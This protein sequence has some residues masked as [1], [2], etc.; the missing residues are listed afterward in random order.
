MGA[1]RSIIKVAILGEEKGLKEAVHLATADLDKLQKKATSASEKAKASA[2]KAV[3]FMAGG[4]IAIAGIA[5]KNGD[6]LNES[7]DQLANSLQN[8]GQS[9]AGLDKKMSPLQKTMEKYGYT[10]V[11]VN[12]SIRAQVESGVKLA[13]AIKRETLIAD[14]AKKKHLDLATATMLVTKAGQGLTKP[15]KA[16][17][18]D[19]PLAAGGALKLATAQ[20]A[21][22]KAHNKVKDAA[23]RVRDAE[24]KA[25][26][27]IADARAKHLTGAAAAKVYA[28]AHDL[29]WKASD[30]LN[31]AQ[32]V[33]RAAQK[34]V[35]DTRATGT[36]ILDLLT[37]RMKGGAEESTKSLA[38]KTAA[39][40]AK[41]TDMTAH[42]GQKLIPILLTLGTDIGAIVEWFGKNKV[43]LDVL[44][45]AVGLFVAS[46][47]TMFIIEKV[48][49]MTEAWTAAQAAFNLVMDANPIVL[50]VGAIALLA[51]GL[52][53]AYQKVGWFH[54]AVDKAWQILQ[55]GYHWIQDNWPLLLAILTGPFGLAVLAIVKNRDKIISFIKEIPGKIA[56]FAGTLWSG[57]TGAWDAAVHWVGKRG[58]A[59]VTWVKNLPGVLVR[60]LAGAGG[61]L[62]TIG[63][64]I[65]KG[66]ASGITGAGHWMIDGL[67]KLFDKIPGF[68]VISSLVKHIPGIGALVGALG[69]AEG[70]IVNF[71][72]SGR[73]AML[74]GREAII[75]LDKPG[76]TMAVLRQAGLDPVMS[77]GQMSRG[78]AP[79]GGTTIY[80]FPAGIS[81]S[82]VA[83]ATRRHNARN[84]VTVAA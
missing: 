46:V 30:K 41:F 34:K 74:H 13:D 3:A 52:F 69:F 23:W 78:T 37:K 38:G 63:E 48:R 73:L 76:R 72:R 51:A 21:L 40:K 36:K 68:G 65:V 53:V 16:L 33:E 43:A 42:L 45:V 27:M 32:D 64:D 60:A 25:A 11:Q 10:N 4:A 1:G 12:E 58:E 62:L 20:G 28:H 8:T 17:G 61:K 9:V 39:L 81:P 50:V 83:A 14:L 7:Q 26:A 67:R 5:I 79:S 19:L 29:V 82:A 44:I 80:N 54:K 66:I 57:I 22:E 15:L 75:P 35:N 84:G 59:I 49:K 70:G 47:V 31:R 2:K 56:A 55:T 18:I 24:A 77:V 71:P 6:A